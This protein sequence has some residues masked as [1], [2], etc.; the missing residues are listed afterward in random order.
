MN[1]KDKTIALV[2]DSNR[3]IGFSTVK[4]LL[5]LNHIVILTSRNKKDG[6]G[7]SNNG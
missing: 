2:T 5:K 1:Q 6:P 3:G 4:E 7:A